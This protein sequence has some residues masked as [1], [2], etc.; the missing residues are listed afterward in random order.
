MAFKIGICGAPNTG[1]SY[2]RRNLDG[3]RTFL[4]LPSMKATHLKG[5]DQKPLKRLNLSTDKSKSTKELMDAMGVSNRFSVMVNLM[6]S[7]KDFNVKGNWEIMPNLTALERY[8]KFINDK[9]PHINTI[10]IPDFT[11]YL[12]K[13]IAS[14]DFMKRNKGGEAFARFWELAANTLNT[15][16]IKADELRDDLM[17]VIEFHSEYDE[18]AEEYKIFTPGGKMLTDKFKPDSYFDVMLYTA[19]IP[20]ESGEV[21]PDSYKFAMKRDS[22]YPARS[23]D[24]FEDTYMPNDL[25]PILNEVR[26][27]MGMEEE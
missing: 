6:K 5:N 4:C 12:S 27:Y 24:I 16:F 2:S 25:K 3:D 7:G 22:K 20:G 15:F 14:D 18:E 9:M 1:K 17:I 10:I 11:H 8:L 26:E 23:M 13:I 19:I 21:T